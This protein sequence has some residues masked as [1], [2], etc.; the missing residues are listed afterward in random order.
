MYVYADMGNDTH[1]HKGQR[2]QLIDA[3]RAKEIHDELVLKAMNAVPRHRFLDSSFEAFAY[4]DAAFPIR[5]DQTISQ[6]YTVAFQSQSLRLKPGAKVLEIGTGCGYQ[7]AVLVEMGFKVFS[8]ERQ[9]SLFDFAKLLL[10]KLGY[11]LHQ[12]FGDGYLGMPTFAPFDG[13]IV[14]AAAPSV[15]QALLEQLTIGGALIIPIGEDTEDQVMHRITRTDE[16][17]WERESLG[18]FRFVPML[19][20]V[21]RGG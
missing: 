12:K 1:K 18:L 7:A 13:I 16:S 17:K 19:K 5:A 14:T 4:R 3:L 21:N 10:P 9:K 6:P 2:Q 20:D 8:I 15:P 11:R